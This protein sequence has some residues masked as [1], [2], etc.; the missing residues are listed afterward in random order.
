MSSNRC[1]A[2]QWSVA[3]F[4]DGDGS[5][6]VIVDPE[7]AADCLTFV[8]LSGDERATDVLMRPATSISGRWTPRGAS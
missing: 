7:D 6:E 4:L 8:N 3:G 2:G 1:R 5:L